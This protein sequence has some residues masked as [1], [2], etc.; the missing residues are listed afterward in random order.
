MILTNN[1]CKVC[2][3]HIDISKAINNVINCRFCG[4]SYSVQQETENTEV[5]ARMAVAESFMASCKF[6]EAKDTFLE[7]VKIDAKNASAYFG[8]ALAE[9]SVQYLPHE[10]LIDNQLI[11]KLIPISHAYTLD[12]SILEDKNYLKALMLATA[13]QKKQF[14]EEAEAIEYIRKK[15]FEYKKNGLYF[16]TFI[17]VKV[18]ELD[19]SKNKT[20]D[21]IFA[22]NIFDMLQ[23]QG[24]KPFYSERSISPEFTGIN[25]E[26]MIL[27]AL[28]SCRC[29]ILVCFDKEYLN[30]PWVRNEYRRYISLMT[31]DRKPEESLVFV[32]D[33][34][35]ID[36]LPGIRG[37]IQSLNKNDGM[38]FN[39]GLLAFVEKNCKTI[40]K[41]AVAEIEFMQVQTGEVSTKAKQVEGVQISYSQLGSTDVTQLTP[42]EENKLSL[43]NMYLGRSMFEDAMFVYNGILKNNPR[44]RHALWGK[45]LCT[46]EAK[47]ESNLAA[48]LH[49]MNSWEDFKTLINL[50]DKQSANDYAQK[51]MNAT[52]EY[53]SKE[54]NCSDAEA[55]MLVENLIIYKTGGWDA[56]FAKVKNIAVTRL[57]ENLLDLT[58]KYVDRT[59]VDEHIR[60]YNQFAAR[61][62]DVGYDK[63]ANKYFDRTL[64]LD[65]G[66]EQ[67]LICKFRLVNRCGNSK[68]YIFNKNS[69]IDNYTD[70]DNLLKFSSVAKAQKIIAE[71]INELLK[72]FTSG[73]VAVNKHY[74]EV[75]DRVIAINITDKKGA[76]VVDKDFMVKKLLEMGE[77][78]LIAE[79]YTYAESYFALAL[80]YAENNANAYWGMLKAKLRARDESDLVHSN[81]DISKL[82]EF[83]SVFACGDNEFCNRVV[84][85]RSS[86]K[87]QLPNTI[88]K[89]E[90]LLSDYK[91]VGFSAEELALLNAPYNARDFAKIEK[92]KASKEN[93]RIE[94]EAFQAKIR[95]EKEALQEKKRIEE[96]ILQ[97]EKR[98]EKIKRK[99]KKAIEKKE[100]ISNL[101][102]CVV[103]IVAF[104][105][106]LFFYPF[107]ISNA[108]RKDGQG[109]AIAAIVFSCIWAVIAI[110]AVSYKFTKKT[111]KTKI[112]KIIAILVIIGLIILKIASVPGYF[113][114]FSFREGAAIRGYY[115]TEIETVVPEKILGVSV[116]QIESRAFRWSDDTQGV[117][118]PYGVS[119][120]DKAAFEN[121]TA[122]KSVKIPDSVTE[123]GYSA[124][125]YCRSLTSI[126]IPDSVMGIGNSAFAHCTSLSSIYVYATVPPVLEKTADGTFAYYKNFE[127]N[128][129]GRKIYVPE[130][131]L[132]VY[133]SAE[134]WNVYAE[135][136]YPIP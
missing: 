49:R 20:Q 43:A 126:G 61:S 16:D 97:Q 55:T 80:Q 23:K 132:E 60:L 6:E 57:F 2:N 124:F 133:K 83:E 87:K 33:I 51:F 17:C 39:P 81:V 98:R 19:N 110:I 10:E 48:S 46:L 1:I 3:E 34:E 104:I 44:N 66:N 119:I 25:Y 27:Y 30:S 76:S 28:H 122:L 14:I 116:K 12:K 9:F 70:F 31:D 40:N 109:K 73:A 26:A 67:A 32:N 115:G 56:F 7:V 74:K 130:Q 113:Y 125:A 135:S 75:F 58:L 45:L 62:M 111:P 134:G 114:T 36:R 13:E 65:E 103:I 99:E 82:P 129:T 77:A 123:I 127:D 86:Q 120:I 24:Y 8:A 47:E 15:F 112:S 37:A 94:E 128:I 101:I 79:E 5:G 29:M 64:A 106:I 108:I 42:D 78:C 91:V 100:I 22:Y 89:K 121:C 136:I 35:V 84:D 11:K 72:A 69:V 68:N 117:T 95:K 118:I 71:L 59:N 92:V 4:A 52:V 54:N 96:E 18:T 53:I 85:V 93:K 88:A 21:S 90:K 38:N 41:R 102:G 107:I 105:L 131:S 63:I 50:S